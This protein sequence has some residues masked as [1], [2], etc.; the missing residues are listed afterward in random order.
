MN[1]VVHNSFISFYSF[2]TVLNNRLACFNMAKI[3]Y[4]V[5]YK[6]L[7]SNEYESS[8]WWPS[9]AFCWAVC[10]EYLN[11]IQFTETTCRK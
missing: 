11:A 8:K 2:L 1:T 5:T 3:I 4:H 6:S 9:I 10:P 7:I